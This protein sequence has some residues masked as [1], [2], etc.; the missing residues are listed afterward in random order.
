MYLG[1][2]IFLFNRPTISFKNQRSYILTNK[3]PQSIISKCVILKL[4]HIC[5]GHQHF[6]AF[7]NGENMVNLFVSDWIKLQDEKRLNLIKIGCSIKMCNLIARILP[8]A[9]D[10][11]VVN[12]KIIWY[13]FLIDKQS[14]FC[15]IFAFGAKII[16]ICNKLLIV[17]QQ[18]L[19]R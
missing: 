16:S 13:V 12:L 4:C 8:I 10:E 18:K 1:F 19:L 6:L 14:V 17:G 3:P 2:K 15:S 5:H 9:I 7:A 11:N